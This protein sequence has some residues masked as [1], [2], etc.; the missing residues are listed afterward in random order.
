MRPSLKRGPAAVEEGLKEAK[1]AAAWNQAE[2]NREAGPEAVVVQQGCGGRR[3]L[4]EGPARA[5][6]EREMLQ[7][8]HRPLVKQRMLKER[9]FVTVDRNGALLFWVKGPTPTEAC[10]KRGEADET[11][12]GILPG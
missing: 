9:P 6:S 11:A 5:D 12:G 4:V 8:A 3:R 10:L 7:V 2:R 1:Q